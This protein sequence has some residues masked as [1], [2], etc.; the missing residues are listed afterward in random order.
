MR[1]KVDGEL[2][3]LLKEGPFGKTQQGQAAWWERMAELFEVRGVELADAGFPSLGQEMGSV[4][5]YHRERGKELRNS[6]RLDRR[7]L[8]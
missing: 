2:N 1:S 7:W 6:P 4:A 8:S 3:R 5:E